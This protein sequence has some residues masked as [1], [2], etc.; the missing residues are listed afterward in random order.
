MLN[1]FCHLILFI[2]NL[3]HLIC[4]IINLPTSIKKWAINI[5]RRHMSIEMAIIK[6]VSI[7]K[8]LNNLKTIKGIYINTII[9]IKVKLH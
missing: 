2:I 5:M 4:L 6:A 7:Y 9:I 1:I 8:I 3:F